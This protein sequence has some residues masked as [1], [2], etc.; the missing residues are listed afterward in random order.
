MSLGFIGLAISYALTLTGSLGGVVNAFVETEREMVSVE[1]VRQYLKE[2]HDGLEG[3]QCVSFVSPP[4]SWPSRG[5]VSFSN[6]FFRYR[7]VFCA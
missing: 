6:V 7:S 2:E 5:V 3:E 1:R 4:F